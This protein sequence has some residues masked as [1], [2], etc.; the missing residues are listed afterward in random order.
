MPKQSRNTRKNE[1][2]AIP[3]GDDTV[4]MGPGPTGSHDPARLDF[5]HYAGHTIEE[6]ATIDPDYLHWLARHPS[7]APYRAEIG[8]VLGS[9][10][11][12][13]EY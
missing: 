2:A 11:R 7:G 4:A 3:I 6:L 12:S 9:P 8:R 5:G 10:L 1:Q 13:T